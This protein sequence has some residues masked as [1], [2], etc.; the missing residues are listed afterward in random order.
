M[1]SYSNTTTDQNNRGGRTRW[2]PFTPQERSI[3]EAKFL[4][5]WN[6]LDFLETFWNPI[7]DK[8]D[9]LQYRRI[10]QAWRLRLSGETFKDIGGELGIDER[11]ACALVSGKNLR[12][13]L[14]QMYLVNQVSSKLPAKW[15][16][17]LDATPKP[18]N[19][20]PKA[21]MVPET[22]RSYQ[23][24]L[25]FLRQFPSPQADNPGLKYF[26]LSIEWVDRHKPELFGFLLGFLVG[27]AGKNYPEYEHRSRRPS[28]T[29]L[30]T[31]MAIKE[32]NIRILRFFQ[33]CLAS[34]RIDSHRQRIRQ[35]AIRWV[36]PANSL[37]T[38][39][40][41][42]C[43]GIGPGQR[44]S[45]NPIRMN[46]LLKC[47]R[48]FVAAFFQGL[49]ESDGC[50]DKHGRYCDIASKVNSPFLVKLL[51]NFDIKSHAYPIATPNITRITLRESLKI[52][53]FNPHIRSYR[54]RLM[55]QHAMRKH[56][57]PPSPSFF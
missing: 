49:A 6:R 17:V 33:L 26:G 40:I 12:P 36:T 13:F 4:G 41:R 37:L 48:E 14:G 47:P 24:V 20:Y 43:L 11:K 19:M 52:P 8:K 9:L 28:K 51:H 30:S 38:W 10:A 54:F 39:I 5:N 55:T 15:K 7:Y 21:V 46:W 16:W 2:P 42:V 27:D 32:S 1:T 34:I 45:R 53:L 23:D 35:A 18:T 31:N 56:L 57:L 50:V 25:D 22:I 44:T 3:L 29:T